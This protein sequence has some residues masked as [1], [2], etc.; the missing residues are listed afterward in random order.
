MSKLIPKIP[1]PAINSILTPIN[2]NLLLDFRY[3]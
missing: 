2:R 3:R 1:N